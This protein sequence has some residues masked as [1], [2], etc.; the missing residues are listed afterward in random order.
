M[1]NLYYQL[2]YQL[3][4]TK[5]SCYPPSPKFLVFKFS[6][7][8]LPY[9]SLSLSPS[10]SLSLSLPINGIIL[11]GKIGSGRRVIN[12]LYVWTRLF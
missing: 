1:A 10:L 9:L 12:L 4:K 8:P 3:N 6:A 5:L 2:N 7:P 11:Q